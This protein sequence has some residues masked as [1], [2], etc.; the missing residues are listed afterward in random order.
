MS[1]RN[2]SSINKLYLEKIAKEMRVL[3]IEEKESSQDPVESF[4][5]LFFPSLDTVYDAARALEK[6]HAHTYD[7][8]II[9]IAI[10]DIGNTKF[11]AALR[12]HNPHQKIIFLSPELSTAQLISVMNAGIDRTIQKPID[13]SDFTHNLLEVCKAIYHRNLFL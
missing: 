13:F 4:L 6:Y 3:L 7:L 1:S 12:T 5:G 9:N 2:D 8:V 10:E 11:Y